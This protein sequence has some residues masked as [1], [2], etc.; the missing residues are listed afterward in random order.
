MIL[1]INMQVF[2][3][4]FGGMGV[5]SMYCLGSKYYLCGG[6]IRPRHYVT[7]PLS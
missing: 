7:A 2:G 4:L 6:F 5:A 3:G 1:W